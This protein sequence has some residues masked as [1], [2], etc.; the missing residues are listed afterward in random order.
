MNF[1][2]FSTFILHYY[3]I[4]LGF[5]CVFLHSIDCI[6]LV[7]VYL[8]L[9]RVVEHQYSRYSWIQLVCQTFRGLDNIWRDRFGEIL[10]C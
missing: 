4:I 6:I 2:Q 3:S 10:I 7:S 8:S 5:K 1:D 9:A